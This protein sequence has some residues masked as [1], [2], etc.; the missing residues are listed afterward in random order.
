[1][2]MENTTSLFKKTAWAEGVSLLVLLGISMPLKY[3]WH[4]EK[5]VLYTGW[6][7]GLLFIIYC[8]MALAV[9]QKMKKSFNWLIKAGIAAFLPYGT[10]YFVKRYL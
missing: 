2:N 7:H 1:M 10:F 5:A 8:F 9:Q 4:L 6:V 3:I